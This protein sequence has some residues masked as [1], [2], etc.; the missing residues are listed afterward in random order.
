MI[1]E[2]IDNYKKY[3]IE[4]NLN[5]QQAA[6]AVHISRPYLS[7]ILHGDRT[8]S[9]ALLNRMESV[10]KLGYSNKI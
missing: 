3:I 10:I 4:N 9:M 7:H 8:P 6:D 1:Q 2:I 5:Q